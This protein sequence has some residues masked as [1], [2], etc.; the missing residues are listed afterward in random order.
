MCMQCAAGAM[1][2][3]GAASGSRMYLESRFPV[4][5]RPRVR[6]V[7]RRTIMV[8]GV[9]AAGVLGPS[10]HAPGTSAG[11]AAAPAAAV[12]SAR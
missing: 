3:V 2:A 10:A 12:A 6:K 5:A 11:Q 7:A 4:F 9:L 8:V 1:T